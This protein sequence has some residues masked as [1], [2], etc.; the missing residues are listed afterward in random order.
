LDGDTTLLARAVDIVVEDFNITVLLS[1]GNLGVQ[2][3]STPADAQSA[4]AVGAVDVKGDLADFSSVGPT[5]DGR[6]KPEVCG[7]GVHNYVANT[8]N[9]FI[10]ST[11]TYAYV[12]GTSLA[13][14]WI[15][16]TRMQ[17]I[18][19]THFPCL[20]SLGIATLLKEMHP[21]WTAPQIRMAILMTARYIEAPLT[22]LY[23]RNIP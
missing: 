10:Y 17:T 3:V 20:Q 19:G 6:I 2:G 5:F 12:Q 22:I 1:A 4:I 11:T 7:L 16:G 8:T 18:P 9:E 23:I 21:E 14:P 13:A 15:A